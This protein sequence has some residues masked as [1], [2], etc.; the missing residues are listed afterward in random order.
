[1]SKETHPDIRRTL[2]FL[3]RDDEILIAMKKRGF[4]AGLW[5]GVGGKIEAGES[6]TDALSRETREEIGVIPMNYWQVAELDFIQD[7]ETEPWHMYVYAYLCDEWQGDPSESEEMSPEWF[8][9]ADIPYD[10][11]WEDDRHW[12]PQVLA[13]EKVTGMF[14]FDADDKL[15]SHSVMVQEFLPLEAASEQR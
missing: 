8:N 5:N 12:L 4:G 6:V 7:A 14:T 1:M 2:L 3:R 9:I 10:Q 13:G 11:M 15:I